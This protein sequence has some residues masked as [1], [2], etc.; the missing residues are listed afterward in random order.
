MNNEFLQQV[1]FCTALIVGF[2]FAIG[3]HPFKKKKK[4]VVVA[5]ANPSLMT[6]GDYFTFLSSIIKSSPTL[7]KLQE[8][9]PKI[10]QF[11]DKKYR[12]K[13]SAYQLKQY[14]SRLLEVYCKR[15]EELTHE[16]IV[17]HPN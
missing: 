3:L 17:L 6:A 2:A 16:R 5:H 8:T 11:Y 13:I 14:Y 9:M 4:L 7:E 10:D 1:A 15:E 12:V